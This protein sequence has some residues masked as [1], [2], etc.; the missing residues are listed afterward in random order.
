MNILPKTISMKLYLRLFL[1]IL[2]L[3][4][5]GVAQNPPSY[6]NST[7]VFVPYANHRSN[8]DLSHSPTIR[9]GFNNSDQHVHFTMDTGS[10]GIIAS[11]DIFQPAPDAQNLGPG[12]Q[13]YSSSGIIEEGTWWT[14]TQNIYDDNGTLLA[15]TNAPVLQVTHVR[16]AKH[17]RSCHSKEHPRHIA[18]FGMGF[19]R[20]SK[21]QKRGTPAYNP[22]LNLLAVRQNGVLSP[23][24]PNWA[25]GYVVTPKGIYLGLTTQNTQ[26]AGWVKLEPWPEYSTPSL[27]EWKAAPM[28]LVVNGTA[29]DGTILMDTGVGTSYLTLPFQANIGHLAHCPRSSLRECAPAG[30]EIQVFLPNQYNPVASYTFTVGENDNLMEPKGIHVKR[31]GAPFINTSRH[32]FQGFNYIY[33]NTNGYVGYIWNGWNRNNTGFVIPSNQTSPPQFPFTP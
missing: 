26:N 2:S 6:T 17:A 10:V 8:H 28:T 18:M 15:V 4:A 19:A 21:A 33:D 12:Y 3:S 27:P 22:F 32:V 11:A 13:Y 5:K 30:T 29:G 24:P 1:L 16:C 23:L 20:E 25:N 31:S 9:I 14:A 7:S